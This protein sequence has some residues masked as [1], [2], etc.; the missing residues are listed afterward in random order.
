M[1][2]KTKIGRVLE[3]FLFGHGSLLLVD[4]NASAAI[5]NH[6]HAVV[7]LTKAN[8]C[9]GKGICD[10][11]IC[12][13]KVDGEGVR[14]CGNEE[15]QGHDHGRSSAVHISNN[16]SQRRHTCATKHTAHNEA[17]ASLGVAAQTAHSQRHDGREADGLEE[18]R[19]VEH[20]HT[21]IA[22]FRDSR[23]DENNAHA[24]EQQE[25]PSWL[26]KVHDSYTGKSTNGKGTLSA[27]KKLRAQGRGGVCAGLGD[28]V[29]EITKETSLLAP[30]LTPFASWDCL[31]GNGNLGTSV[32][33]LRKRS[34][35]QS[36]L[37]D[38]RLVAV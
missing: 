17:G 27:G 26:H 2:K 8:L 18:E 6:S 20:R 23:D 25:D 29:D 12:R 36:V 7:V 21:G 1:K 24:K 31:P 9:L 38:E 32:A 4:Y 33:E 35:K 19:H 16:T 13:H 37:F 22:A 15:G 34:V 11:P 28:I 3:L 30:A 10:V 5:S 14:L